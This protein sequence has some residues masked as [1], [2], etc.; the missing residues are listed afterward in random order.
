MGLR[1]ELATDKVDEE[2]GFFSVF[3]VFQE[4]HILLSPT[5]CMVHKDAL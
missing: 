5:E 4:L 3:S 2:K 1:W